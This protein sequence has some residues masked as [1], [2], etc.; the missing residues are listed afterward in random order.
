MKKGAIVIVVMLD[1]D[2]DN[3][4]GKNSFTPETGRQHD[5]NDGI[6]IGVL[7]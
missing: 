5:I 6:V 3:W 7:Q 4:T 1:S 2:N